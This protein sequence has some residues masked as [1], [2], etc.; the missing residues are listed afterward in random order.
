M[1]D[2]L[3]FCDKLQVVDEERGIDYGWGSCFASVFDGHGGV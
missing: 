1:E 3:L 2:G